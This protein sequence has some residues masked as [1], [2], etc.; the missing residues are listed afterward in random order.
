MGE[1]D[2]GAGW[3]PFSGVTWSSR[4]LPDVDSGRIERGDTARSGCLHI[5]MFVQGWVWESG[6]PARM[7]NLGL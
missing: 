2:A 7:E 4:V 3:R 1:P 6:D 5:A